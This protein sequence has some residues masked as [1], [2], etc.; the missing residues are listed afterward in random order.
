MLS[1]WWRPK[2]DPSAVSYHDFIN[3]DKSVE[4]IYISPAKSL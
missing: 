3:Q 1:L 4:I 2:K